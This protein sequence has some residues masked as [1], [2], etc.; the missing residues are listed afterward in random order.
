MKHIYPAIFV[1]EKEGGYSIYFPDIEGCYSQGDNVDD[2]FAMGKDALA[3]WLAHAE[4]KQMPIAPASK[5]SDITPKKNETV[6]L[7]EVD[8]DIYHKE[9]GNKSVKKTLTIPAWLN[10]RAEEAGVNFSQTLQEAL[11]E[12]LLSS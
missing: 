11:K 8:T 2:A 6:A 9:W 5:A 1:K 10:A 7:I 4:D 12:K 3:L